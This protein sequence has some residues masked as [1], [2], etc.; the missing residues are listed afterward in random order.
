M[1]S[2]LVLVF[3]VKRCFGSYVGVISE[4]FVHT[5]HGAEGLLSL[6]KGAV[7]AVV[8]EPLTRFWKIQKQ[9]AEAGRSLLKD[10]QSIVL[11]CTERGRASVTEGHARIGGGG[12]APVGLVA[13]GGGEG[14]APVGLVARGLVSEACCSE[15]GSLL[16]PGFPF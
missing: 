9:E 11:Y 14:S 2:A 1:A 10:L 5:Q 4:K 8:T 3:L 15:R 12:S 7:W 6:E 13:R 16:E